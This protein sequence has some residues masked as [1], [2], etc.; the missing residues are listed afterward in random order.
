MRSIRTLERNRIFILAAVIAVLGAIPIFRM[1]MKS[2]SWIDF[3][4]QRMICTYVL[5]GVNPYNYIGVGIE[6]IPEAVRDIGTIPERW[7]AVPWGTVLG[8]VFYF[9]FL[10]HENAALCYFAVCFISLATT[11]AYVY[12]KA[13]EISGKKFA[14]LCLLL[15]VFAP[16]FFASVHGGNAGGII[17]CLLILVWTFGRKHSVISGILLG[18]AMV[19]PQNAM[20]ICFALLLRKNFAALIIAAVIDISAWFAASVMTET[21]MAELLA[22]FLSFTGEG[23]RFLG[24]F[25]VFTDNT[26]LALVSSMAAGIIFVFT[27]DYRFC[28]RDSYNLHDMSLCF[29]YI[30]ST[31]WCYAYNNDNYILLLPA[32]VCLYIMIREKNT[33]MRILWFALC[34]YCNYGYFV[35]NRIVVEFLQHI[36]GQNIDSILMMTIYETGLIIIALMIHWRLSVIVRERKAAQNE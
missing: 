9:G 3:P 11:A 27:M 5:R 13:A 31:F 25:T 15:A 14:L 8:N 4:G 1:Y 7:N 28:F 23:G 29:S 6:N 17:C 16:N 36:T 20:I 22:G 12:R 34:L 26:R 19:K 24:I 30:A 33:A 21:S 2:F 10:S 32:I 18:L 35:K